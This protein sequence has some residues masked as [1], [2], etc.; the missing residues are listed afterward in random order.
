MTRA[1]AFSL[2]ALVLYPPAMLLP[3]LEIQ[4]MGHSRSATIWSGVVEMLSDGQI[5]IGLIV[6][7]CSIVIPIIKIGG[8]LWLAGPS[9]WPAQ[10]PTHSR[11]A[12][13]T[14][15]H[16][17]RG[18]RKA[19]TYRFIDWIGRWGMVDVLLVAILIA[20]VKLGAFLQIH[21]GPGIVA[22]AGVVVMSLLAS[23]MFNPSAIWEDESDAPAGA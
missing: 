23:A 14:L 17:Q 7:V 4:K 16:K 18:R 21:A 19:F 11:S 22:F 6:L 2:G 1:A 13:Q 12:A 9:L 8:M 5:V 10:S 3:V 20:A 15:V